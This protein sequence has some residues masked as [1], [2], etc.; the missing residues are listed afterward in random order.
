MKRNDI[1]NSPR[2]W[3]ALVLSP[4][5]VAAVVLCVFG[6]FG[7]YPFGD[8]TAAW[9]D[10]NQQVVPLLCQFK[11]ILDGGSGMFL[12]FKNASGMNFWGVFFFFL[13][14]PFT[15]LVKFVDKSDMLLFANILILLKMC[16]CSFT[17]TLYF[18]KS[19]EHT[20]LD[21]AGAGMLGFIYAT[22][23]YVMLFYQNVIWLDM[24]YLFPLLLLSLEKLR[25][26]GSGL[27]Y[28]AVMTAMMAVNYYIGYMVVIFLLLIAAV[29]VFLSVKNGSGTV[30]AVC[31]R[32]LICSGCA[33]LLSAA[34]WLPCFVQ[35]TTSGRKSSL[36]ENLSAGDF[37]TDYE[38]V[39]P[40]M[41]CSAVMLLAAFGNVLFIRKRSE[42]HK[43]WLCMF[44]LLSV[45]LVIEPVNKMW[46]TGS[47]MSFPA[48]YAFM[49]V[50]S[51][52]IL[53]AYVLREKYKYKGNVK[54]YAA[55]GLICAADVA[56]YAVFSASYINDAI[57]VLSS[58]TK[59][60]GGSEASFK[61]MCKLLIVTM[62]CAAP[63]YFLYRR[64]WI[65][66]GI[67]M[68]FICAVTAVETIGYVRIYMTTA[69]E[70]SEATN[71]LQR[72][73]FDLAGRIDDD[74]FYRVKTSA[75]IFDY[76]MI[77]A[78]GYNSIGHYT[79]LTDED[80]MF[81]MKKMGY[82][83]VWMEVGTC[84]G[85]ELTDALL[86]IG[87]EIS[88]DV[89]EDSLYSFKGYSIDPTSVSLPLGVVSQSGFE[90][91][92]IPDQMTRAEIQQY[93][94][95]QI[96]GGGKLIYP[97]EP[98]EG[99]VSQIEGRYF[100]YEGDRIIYR[101][102]VE[103]KQTLYFDCFD[104]LTNELSEP[105][106]NSFSVTVNGRK[107]SRSYPY[108][109]ENGVLKL[110]EF[111]DERVVIEIV[112]L[113]D[114]DCSSYGVFGLDTELLAERCA[115]A[116]TAELSEKKNGL[117]GTAELDEAGTLFLSVPYQ[118]GYE[119][120]V[121]GESVGYRK[122]LSGFM[123]FDLPAG[124]SEIEITFTPSGLIPGAVMS[125]IGAAA[126][127]AYLILRK[128]IKPGEKTAAQIDGICMYF[129]AA[130]GAIAF[131]AVYLMPVILNIFFWKNG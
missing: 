65:F 122:A 56:L 105:I 54:L 27:S 10:M 48:R 15:L 130:L 131:I 45:P 42:S 69:S 128:R 121:N 34:V 8:R 123:A 60:L 114:C 112:A 79:S 100:S 16:L 97:Y 33:A 32:F 2:R 104:K 116:Q 24:M 23:G 53:C 67:F 109:K 49:T 125:V 31:R 12:S 119:I 5:A 63:I 18:T 58:Y 25:S 85:T 35:Y 62:L 107:I 44:M 101:P 57:D 99:E 52:L 86:C 55:G 103:G 68:V 71:E 106:Y 96:F 90:N 88:H 13:A 89:S 124:K 76:N 120:K 72:E 21:A 113:K 61:G 70:R 127:A 36:A 115:D 64:G 83:S 84:G 47:Y 11:D 38:T 126:T 39:F 41:M 22:S 117:I 59:S 6:R 20:G 50:F 1:N 91:G 4:L 87:Y 30:G 110:G 14:S 7:L 40:V 102:Y 51:A 118:K 78:M 93:I 66:K 81:A 17:A 46:H 26:G 28:I 95:T 3:P 82:T 75:K 19:R 80:Y 108:S 94:F 74:G 43:L 92:A 98:D 129:T 9:C 77:G 37:V 29:Y 73:V 111:E